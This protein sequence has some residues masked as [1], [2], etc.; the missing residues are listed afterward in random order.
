[1]ASPGPTTTVSVVI[2]V[3]C[4]FAQLG[5]L[6]MSIGFCFAGVPS[7]VALPAIDAPLGTAEI[8][9]DEATRA[10]PTN[11]IS[12]ILMLF[13]L[14]SPICGLNHCLMPEPVGVPV[15]RAA[16]TISAPS[17]V[18]FHKASSRLLDVTCK[19]RK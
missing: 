11:K 10:A 9:A 16:F 4:S 6:D 8:I 2:G 15:I 13:V 18:L 1:M 3:G 19:V 14:L 5:S 7:Y 17:F 12:L